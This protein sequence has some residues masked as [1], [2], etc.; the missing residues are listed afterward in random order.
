MAERTSSLQE[1]RQ[2]E[3]FSMERDVRYQVLAKRGA[4]ERGG[5]KTINI[6]SRGVLFTCQ[7]DLQPGKRVQLCI[8]WPVPLN[9]KCA[10]KLVARGRVVRSE[11]GRAA[12][13]IQQHEFRT[14][15]AGN[16][17]PDQSC[18]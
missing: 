2:S 16:A 10:L 9:D 4:E 17:Q 15:S 12:I 8:N 1:R 7:R 13:E 11:E 3:R 18:T 5:G 14:Q 6:S